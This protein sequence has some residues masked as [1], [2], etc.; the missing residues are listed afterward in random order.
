MVKRVGLPPARTARDCENAAV[1]LL[2]DGTQPGESGE[3]ETW[4][5]TLPGGAEDCFPGDG[6][7]IVLPSRGMTLHT[8]MREVALEVVQPQQERSRYTIRAANEASEP[9]RFSLEEAGR[10]NL[11]QVKALTK[12]TVGASYI[13]DVPGAEVTEVTSTT[14]A[15]DTGCAPPVGGGFEVRRTDYGWGGENDRNLAGRF[16]MAVFTLPRLSRAQEYYLRQYDGASPRR[17][18]R[19]STLLRVDYPL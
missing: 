1:M 9:A 13:A 14:I 3:Y 16:A 5:D 2:E 18:S 12:E 10:Q 17:Y 6:L 19:Y 8:T 11:G 15:V 7:E 4:S